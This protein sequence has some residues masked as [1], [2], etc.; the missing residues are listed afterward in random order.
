MDPA[1]AY[2]LVAVEA[3]MPGILPL[4]PLAGL[5]PMNF[6]SGEDSLRRIRRAA[7]DD[8]PVSGLTHR[9]YKYPARFSP[10]FASA[11]I[12]ELS[13]PG[14][15]V[16]DPYMGGGTTVVEAMVA[17]RQSVG[18][19]LN[20]L[21][22]FV[23][24][25]KTSILTEACELSLTIWMKDIL[26]RL[27][28]YDSDPRLADL[29]CEQRTRNLNAPQTRALKK[30]IGLV[31]ISIEELPTRAAQDI[32]RCA[33]L[34][35]SQWALNGKKVQVKL[36]QFRERLIL[37][38]QKIID[39][40][41]TLRQHTR[42]LACFKPTLI[43]ASSERIEDYAPFAGGK[44]AD[45]VVT[46]PPYPGVHILYHRWQVDGR[47]ESPVPY[48]IAN[49]LDGQGGSYYT[50]GGRKDD[51]G[52]EYF[53]QSLLTLQ[54]IR[55]VMK[56][57]GVFAQMIAF[58]DPNRQLKRYL[59]NMTRAGF[60]ELKG[61]GGRAIRTWRDVPGRSWHATLKGRTSGAREVVLLHAAV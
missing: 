27:S 3:A 7:R 6:L 58:S 8:S 28:Y 15:L 34:N 42:S 11:V 18:C 59:D 22:L 47:K 32:A 55:S 50:F 12:E 46:S 54:A 37:T 56:K 9:H 23:A 1:S 19:D 13:Q 49:C 51:G 2:G 36:K 25:A 4:Q 26:P 60:A 48:W 17:G 20:S 29:I 5:I 38:A 24:R 41:N 52:V 31:L 39:D 61:K 44:K 33:L 45:L 40:A 43:H 16:L 30:Y 10:A 21:A 57:G 53:K 35:C 14:A